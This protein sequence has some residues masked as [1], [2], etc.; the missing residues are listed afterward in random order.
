MRSILAPIYCPSQN[1]PRPLP[2]PPSTV[3]PRPSFVSRLCLLPLLVPGTCHSL[4]PC[5]SSLPCPVTGSRVLPLLVS[6]IPPPPCLSSLIC[7][8]T[9]A[10]VSY[11][12]RPGYPTPTLPLFQ[13][14][15][16]DCGCRLLPFSSRVRHPHSA[17]LPASVTRLYAAL[18]SGCFRGTR[19]QQQKL[20]F[21]TMSCP[22][23][24]EGCAI[25]MCIDDTWHS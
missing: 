3:P 1:G 9:V 10:V 24:F 13:P 20:Y 11:P 7:H 21:S 5:L 14:L 19:K 2:F 16:P 25:V 17:S 8:P 15:S 12:S 18:C 23:D 6:G 4:L 22:T